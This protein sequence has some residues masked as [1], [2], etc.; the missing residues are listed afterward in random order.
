MQELLP[1]LVKSI[2]HNFIELATS[3]V[4]QLYYAKC[5]S[6]VLFRVATVS[7]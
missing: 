6:V 7:H 4:S 2:F 1:V 3:D 5:A